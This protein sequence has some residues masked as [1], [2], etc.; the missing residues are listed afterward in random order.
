MEHMMTTR[1]TALIV[2]LE[3]LLAEDAAATAAAG[4]GKHRHTNAALDHERGITRKRVA[5]Y[6]A[7]MLIATALVWNLFGGARMSAVASVTNEAAA[8]ASVANETATS[9][10]DNSLAVKTDL[11]SGHWRVGTD[12]PP[13]RYVISAVRGTGNISSLKRD[14]SRGINEIFSAYLTTGLRV[15][16]VTTDLEVN[17]IIT[18]EHLGNVSFVPA[19]TGLRTTVSSGTWIV[20]IDIPAGSFTLT[21]ARAGEQGA[22][23]IL[24]G[25]TVTRNEILGKIRGVGRD[26]LPLTLKDGQVLSIHGLNRVVLKER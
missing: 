9:A 8:S 17:E 7:T 6:C 21:N 26:T 4:S 10:H 5:G 3:Q 11:S 22:V 19:A 24:T 15:G 25:D 2:P 13:G 20:G 12:I 14:G 16:T 23:S 18:I 1:P